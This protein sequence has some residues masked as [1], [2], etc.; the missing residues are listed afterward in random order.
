[1]QQLNF[2]AGEV[3]FNSGDLAT[4]AFLIREGTVQLQQGLDGHGPVE[5]HA[6]E[7][8]SEMSLI[9][10]NPHS[11]IARALTEVR[12][13]CMPR[14][15]F[16]HSLTS[17]LESARPFLH[18]LF[19]RLRVV[20]AKLEST[21]EHLLGADNKIRVTIHPVTRRAAATLPFEGLVI[22]SFPFCIGRAASEKEKIPQEANDLWLVDQAPYSVSRTHMSIEREGDQIFIKDRGSNL[23]TIVNDFPIGAKSANR[24][25]ALDDGNNTVIL[26]GRMSRYQFRIQLDREANGTESL[27]Q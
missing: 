23:G 17:A 27:A 26:G 13:D 19:Q 3:I 25:M 22:D 16:E 4:S 6:G 5:L 14:S 12:L 7:V 24:K 8:F 18:A 21:Q 11:T 9:Q 20:S 10:E 1:M 2:A 15:E